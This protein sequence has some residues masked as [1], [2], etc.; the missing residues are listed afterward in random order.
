MPGERVEDLIAQLLVSDRIGSIG[1]LAGGVAHEINN[2]LAVISAN[3]ELL[4]RELTAAPSTS[5]T[6]EL[7]KD[8]REAVER[9]RVI[10]RDL[11]RF[12][13]TGEERAGPVDVETL[14]D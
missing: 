14:L 12:S 2:P 5:E 9:V 7:L 13:S 1:A 6:G 4:Q 3:L 10:V 11:S 8:M